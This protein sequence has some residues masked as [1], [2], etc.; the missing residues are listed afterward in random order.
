[1]PLT[2]PEIL[3][4]YRRQARHYDASVV[5]YY[6]IGFRQA[7]YRKQAVAAL[8]LQ[9]GD[10]VVEL[11]CGTGL[12]FAHLQAVVG[13]G[14]RIIGL[15]LTDQML[16]EARARVQR[17]GWTNVELVCGDAAAYDYPPRVDG[18][19]STFALTLVPE[20]DEVIRRGAAAL[21]PEGRFVVLDFKKPEHAPRWLL[22]LMLL[23][24]KPFAVTLDLAQRHPWES[25]EMHLAEVVMR[26]Y[27]FG[28]TYLAMGKAP[29]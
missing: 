14:G 21:S 1:M 24:T 20:Y 17:A 28:F 23:V 16:D 2:K 12:N 19:L 4:R 5:L 25:M 9:P 3:R 29:R 26:D 13:A 15:D 11:G 8:G 27:Y 22:H 10:T 6:L 7:A 18:V